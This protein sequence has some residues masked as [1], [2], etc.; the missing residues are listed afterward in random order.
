MPKFKV[1]MTSRSNIDGTLL[2]I[3]IQIQ[4]TISL[5]HLWDSVVNSN[6]NSKQHQFRT[7]MF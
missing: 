4:N 3:R 7:F 5:G 6:S 2:S 1:K